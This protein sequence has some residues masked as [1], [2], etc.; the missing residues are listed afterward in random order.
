MS[1]ADIRTLCAEV[2]RCMA[3]LQERGEFPIDTCPADLKAYAM[4]ILGDREGRIVG[5]QADRD[6]WLFANPGSFIEP[7]DPRNA[8][9]WAMVFPDEADELAELLEQQTGPKTTILHVVVSR[10][11]GDP[12]HVYTLQYGVAV[13][14]ILA[15]FDKVCAAHLDADVDYFNLEVD[16]A[17]SS[18]DIQTFTNLLAESGEYAPIKRR[19]GSA[20]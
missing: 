11:K 4:E 12:P 19:E 3:H 6:A 15:F 10:F 16:A 2:I 8:S 20:S 17:Q 13:E 14:P 9:R 1:R 5:L 18:E 7:K